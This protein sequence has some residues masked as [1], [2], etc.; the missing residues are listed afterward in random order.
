MKVSVVSLLFIFVKEDEYISKA[1]RKSSIE[2]EDED[3]NVK[4]EKM[5][6]K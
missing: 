5:K 4:M 3:L 2:L 6:L 1:K